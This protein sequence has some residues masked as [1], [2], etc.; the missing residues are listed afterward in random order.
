MELLDAIEELE[1]PASAAARQQDS[2]FVERQ[3]LFVQQKLRALW[4]RK[5]GIGAEIPRIPFYWVFSKLLRLIEE[6]PDGL[7][8]AVV[9]TELAKLLKQSEAG[10]TEQ[11]VGAPRKKRKI[12]DDED[13]GD[14]LAEGEQEA[15]Q[16]KVAGYGNH[17]LTIEME[18]AKD[19]TAHMYLHQRFRSCVDFLHSNMQYEP[20][21][22]AT[23]PFQSAREIAFTNAKLLERKEVGMANNDRVKFTLLPTSFLTTRLDESRPL[24]RKLLA[25]SISLNQVDQLVGGAQDPAAIQQLM[26]KAKVL[27][28]GAIRPCQTPLYVHRQVILLGEI[29]Q[30]NSRVP[31]G[32]TPNTQKLTQ[33]LHLMVL[34]DDQ[35]ALSRLFRVGDTL[36]IFHPFVHVCD[37]HDA[38]IVHILN[39]Y[40]S[41]Q[42]LVYYFEYGSA[43]VLFCKPCRVGTV[44]TTTPALQDHTE[45]ERPLSCLEEIKSGWNN[46]SLYAHVRSIKVSHGIPLLAAFFYA[47]YDAKTNQPGDMTTKMPPPLDRSIVSKY[48]L[49]VMLQVYISSSKRLLT[50]EV[51][52][53]NALTALRLLP[54]QSVFLDGLVAMDIQSKPVRRFRERAFI[55]STASAPAEFAFPTNAYNTCSSST[56]VLC[57]DWESIFGKQSLF[58]NSSKLTVVN[59]TSGL[60]NTT[61]DRST[62]L[63]SVAMHPLAMVEMTVASVGWLIPGSGRSSS[64]DKTCEKGQSTTCAHKSCYRPLEMM[65]RDPS[66]P[67]LPKWKCSF[68]Q[69]VFFGLED[70]V[71]TYRDLAVTLENGRSQTSPVLVLCQGDTVESLLGLPSD[72]YVQLPLAEKRTTLERVVGNT[73]RI[74]VSRCEPRHVSTSS[75]SSSIEANTSIHLRMD[76][77]QP[78]D[79]FA[80][81]HHLLVALHTKL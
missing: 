17:R 19:I 29:D 79:T 18:N 73:F 37:Q 42:R 53:G 26:V 74:V 40:S 80:A 66:A 12:R 44:K 69:E 14:L 70:T 10:N 13:M 27:D 11:E 72:D 63:H 61:L 51:T 60:M 77:V 34:W 23:F 30:I 38:E 47:Y 75:T 36:S 1:Q 7:T 49:V 9:V 32:A 54:G 62:T 57:S 22:I 8:E 16:A 55:P 31:V 2:D 6:Y 81:A 46:F 68:C 35:V 71:Q 45:I 20:S 43:T 41:Q 56:V 15:L 52:G 5:R 24:D 48:Y 28:I 65:S 4:Q 50:I 78:V 64:I 25:D 3:V 76:M 58:S 39:E 21:S 67:G 59:T 33:G